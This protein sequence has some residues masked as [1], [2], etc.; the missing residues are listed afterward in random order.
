M[1]HE[2]I[3][4]HKYVNEKIEKKKKKSNVKKHVCSYLR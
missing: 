2:K 4:T 3:S 1:K